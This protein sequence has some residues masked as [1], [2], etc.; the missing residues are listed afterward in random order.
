MAGRASPPRRASSANASFLDEID[1]PHGDY[2]RM[3]KSESSSYSPRGYTESDMARIKNLIEED[4]ASEG[5][6]ISIDGAEKTCTK[7][8]KSVKKGR[9]NKRK[10]G[11]K[12]GTP[13]T[14][15]AHPSLKEMDKDVLKE[16]AEKM[17]PKFAVD[18]KVRFEG[19]LNKYGDMTWIYGI[20]REVIPPGERSPGGPSLLRP[21]EYHRRKLEGR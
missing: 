6:F 9:S 1:D 15:G 16:M 17:I 21:A 10:K 3:G 12:K 11:T 14:K 13:Q 18:D 20:V 8:K 4:H 7:K 2:G 5:D 19:E